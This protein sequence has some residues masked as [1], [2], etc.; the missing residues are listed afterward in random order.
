MRTPM[1]DKLN[2]NQMDDFESGAFEQVG[3]IFTVQMYLFFSGNVKVFCT[4]K[5]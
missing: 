3:T 2:I 1:R 4:C 5:L